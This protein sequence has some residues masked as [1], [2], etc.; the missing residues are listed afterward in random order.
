MDTF[1]RG[2]YFLLSSKMMQKYSGKVYIFT[3][4]ASKAQEHENSVF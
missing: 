3:E 4:R 2:R 1:F